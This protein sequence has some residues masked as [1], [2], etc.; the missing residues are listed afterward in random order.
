MSK[1]HNLRVLKEVVVDVRKLLKFKVSIHPQEK[2]KN[3]V[4]WETTS[5][6]S[7]KGP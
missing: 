3:L 1:R 4:K 5:S 7:I 6:N 2:R